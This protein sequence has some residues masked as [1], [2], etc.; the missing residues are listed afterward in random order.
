MNNQATLGTTSQ[1]IDLSTPIV[2]AIMNLTP[3][4]FHD[5][6]KLSTE[7]EVLIQAEKHLAQGATILDIGG[8]SSRPGAEHISE[9]EE[10]LR[11]MQKIAVLK[12]EFP[13]ALISIDTFR[14]GIARQAIETGADIV[15]D[16]SGGQLDP[17]MFVEI[18]KL[19]CP[20]ILMHMRGTPQNMVNMT[21][22]DDVLGELI[23][24]FVLRIN[25]LR[26][27]GVTDIIAD[28]GF[29]F[30]K[31]TEQSY[32]LLKQ[33]GYLKVLGVPLLAGISRKSMIYKKLGISSQ[34]ALNGTSILNTIALVNGAKILR[35]H[36]VK[37]AMEAIKLYKLTYD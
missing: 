7:K 10:G 33:L 29:G 36:D 5:G 18:G 4:S 35:V 12:K 1:I 31:T 2:M 9:D 30:A 25:Q 32:Y 14:S 8:Y 17:E 15:N 24:Y 28:P 37:E 21:E 19:G 3:D 26:E 23:D 27:F 11:V 22:Y 6:G 34:E 13:D 16:I 20:Y